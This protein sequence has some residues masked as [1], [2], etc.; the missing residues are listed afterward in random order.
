MILAKFYTKQTAASVA[1]LQMT[2]CQCLVSF[3]CMFLY[4]GT[5][6]TELEQSGNFMLKFYTA[7]LLPGEL[8][9]TAG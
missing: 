2:A 1:F 3:L 9:L 6:E 8:S 4:V 5:L 7:S